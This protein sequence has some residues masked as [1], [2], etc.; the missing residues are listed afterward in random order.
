MRQSNLLSPRAQLVDSF[1]KTWRYLGGPDLTLEHRFHP[2]RKWRFDRAHLDSKVAI[3]I[4]GGAFIAGRHATGKGSGQDNEK[5]NAAT[6]LGWRVFRLNTWNLRQDNIVSS[7]ETVLA[8][9][10]QE[11]VG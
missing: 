4:D 7:I 10:R 1:D 5:L 3:E 11:Q 8:A 9:L 6:L 2:V